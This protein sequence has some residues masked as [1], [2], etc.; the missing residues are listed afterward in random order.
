MYFQIDKLQLMDERKPQDNIL[1]GEE[2]SVCYTLKTDDITKAEKEWLS[3]Y[4]GRK[5]PF[6]VVDGVA[7][8]A[9]T[10]TTMRVENV[11]DMAFLHVE[12]P[13]QEL[14]EFGLYLPFNFMGKKNGGG[15]QNQFLFNSPYI[16]ADKKILYAYLT[17]PNGAHL[18]VAVLGGVEGWKMDYSPYVGGHYF[19]GLKIL[20]NFDKAYNTVRRKNAFTV[21]FIPVK[22]FDDGLNKLSR[23][24]KVP[25]L[26][27]D[28]NGGE[29]GQK[30]SL[31]SFGEIDTL[32]LT[33]EGEVR[34]VPF[35]KEVV[36]DRQGEMEITPIYQ[37]EAGAS[38]S[39]YA[40]DDLISLY[41]KSMDS[42]NLQT[43]EDF[44]DGNL[45]EHQC[46]ASAMLR[47]LQKYGTRLTKEEKNSYERKLK[48]LLDTITQTDVTK[49]VP[50]RTIYCE[51]WK[52]YP[53]YNVFKSRRI[54]EEFFGITILLDAY[55]YFQDEK[56]YDYAV[57]TTDSFLENYQLADGRIQTRNWE[58]EAEDYT[59][60]CCPMIPLLDM[61]NFL[62]DKDGARSQA[63]FQAGA[64]MAE[65]L[66]RRGFVF[67]TEG[68]TTTLADSEMEDGSISCTA[69]SLL[70]YCK[71]AIRE[72]KYIQKAKEILD[73]HENWVISTPIC[74]M[75]RS[76]LR[77]WETQWEGDADGPAICA[78]HAW[79]IWR[80]E[81]DWLYYS[82]TG[83]EEYYQK[84]VN[85]V[86]TNLSKIDKEGKSYAIYN[87]DLINGGG[88]K[89]KAEEVIFRVANRF[90]DREDCGL[91]RYVW[92]RLN[93]MFL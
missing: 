57:R 38:V 65:Y 3:P 67:P 72:E 70:Y 54:Q 29:V 41:K 69:L 93:A 8:A 2:I 12:S 85:G 39:V 32:R 34:F 37:G 64:K 9:N 16:S 91:S 84:A 24:Y 66:Y 68:G 58:G 5:D 81:A 60:V 51:A 10:Q 87:P 90:P 1:H 77:W 47:F 40:Y 73:L 7:Y 48:I 14:S 45:C 17:K 46:W 43:I 23:F 80:S 62:K 4:K 88:F 15:W 78:G 74:Q 35:E 27:Y 86:M 22:N 52:D 26:H 36:L 31:K 92:V 28:K 13:S 55:A 49:A 42:V 19:V 82:L 71:N 30:I 50:R 59:T 75:N 6:S 76:S 18:M 61:A 79:T 56:Y 63:Y 44:T 20:A 11:E 53:A 89:Q 33:N 83:D 25:F 21:A